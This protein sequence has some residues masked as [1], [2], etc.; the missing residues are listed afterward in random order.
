M[1]LG[2]IGCGKMATAL[3]EGV[4]KS[5]AFASRDIF[6]ADRFADAAKNLA[7]QCG[8]AT[9]SQTNGHVA[10]T[11]NVILLCVKPGDALDA[12]D[13]IRKS[14]A[15]KL[16]ISIVA[17]VPIAV[18]QKIAG[19]KIRFVRVMPNTPALIHKGAAAY[20]LS[21]NATENDAKL[22]EKIFNAVGKVS[23]VK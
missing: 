9:V 19:S 21:E 8:G 5:G 11:A 22:T 4:V 13:E 10:E 6:V 15:G 7:A 16:I 20:A 17:G 23:R 18:L 2:F 1:K 3:A 14:A 12:L